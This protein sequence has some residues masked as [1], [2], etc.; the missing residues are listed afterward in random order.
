MATEY[1]MTMHDYLEIVHRRVW[2]ILISFLLVLSVSVVISL[3]IPASYESSGTIL[4]ESPQISQDIVQSGMTGLADERIEVIKQRVMTRENLLSIINKYNLFK[5]QDKKALP[6]ELIDEMRER[7][8]IELLSAG[9]AGSRGSPTIAFKI[10]FE[11]PHAQL[12]YKVTNE[13]VTLFLDEN[14][15]ARVERATETTQFLEQEANRLKSDLEGVESRVAAFKQEYANALPEH[16]DM[17]MDMLERTKSTIFELERD[18]KT[19][20]LEIRRLNVELT[21]VKA[22]PTNN[23]SPSGS[24]LMLTDLERARLNYDDLLT[25]YKETHPSVKELKRKIEMLE[26]NYNLDDSTRAA[27]SEQAYSTSDNMQVKQLQLMLNSASLRLSS[28]GRQVTPLRE[29]LEQLE[30]QIIQ[31]PQVELGL[32]SL[33]RDH[34]NA[35]N[36]YEEILT[37]QMNAQ[38]SENLEQENKSERFSLIAPPLLPDK[39]TKPNRIK[40]ILM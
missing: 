13:L 5:E 30:Q 22:G 26:K 4:I 28:L 36:K 17:H 20:Q 32:A 23:M 15:K 39:P 14:V 38:I 27:P 40:I 24:T 34:S 37:Q 8:K 21:A 35:K 29:K 3:I 25:R 7:I 1:E 19:A 18:Y 12:T 2:S 11:Y 31:T 10:S 9:K 6:S 33:L 16:L